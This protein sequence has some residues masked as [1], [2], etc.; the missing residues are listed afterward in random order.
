MLVPLFWS[1]KMKPDKAFLQGAV[2]GFLQGLILL[3]WMISSVGRYTGQGSSIGV[4]L[5]IISAFYFALI[6]ALPAWIFAVICKM[7]FQWKQ[8]WWLN[9]LFAGAIW[10]IIDWARTKINPGI[11]WLNYEYAYSQT[12][13]NLPIQMVSYTGT[14]GLTFFIIT[15][16]ALLSSA[17]SEKKYRQLWLPLAL[18]SLLLAIGFQCLDSK[19]NK[20][21]NVKVAI[22]CEN[23]EAQ[24]RWQPE[25]NDSLET[26]FFDLNIQAA[27]ENPQLIV[28][29]ESAL[30]WN[31]AMDD[32][33]IT[34]CL[35]IT[36]PTR[37]RHIIGIFTPF[38]KGK[39]YN[40]AYYIEPDGEI[41]A[42]Y[43]KMQ[44]L[45]FLEEPFAKA[46][47]PF[48]KKSVQNN[49]IPGVKRNLFKTPFSKAGI[50]IC[51]E[52]LIPSSYA[53]SIEKGAGFFVVMS[54]NAW[55]EG[56]MIGMHHFYGTRLMAV[57]FGKDIII[58]SNRGVSGVID[59]RGRIQVSDKG[60]R[61]RLINGTIQT[62]NPSTFYSK[63]G[64]W[65]V[66]ISMIYLLITGFT[67]VT[68]RTKIVFFDVR[69]G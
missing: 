33:L 34:L 65:F 21:N 35:N 29:S 60:L 32:D 68:L 4:L 43:D 17:I 59:G 30:P 19:I 49:I 18:Y 51:N 47:L 8:A 10:I 58:N 63:H 13:W 38:E 53:E 42:R 52:S 69:F 37:A 54:N 2:C 48:F 15:I 7:N 23:V 46:K 67:L 44:L 26:I 31:L 3:F 20:E 5:W 28:W 40:S 22:I 55:F 61:P 39:Q 56:S 64:N 6:T 9:A 50:L 66:F 24:Q 14:G 11:P 57:E 16:N 36:W 45:S 62:K 12:K 25:K 27:K 41:A 1:I